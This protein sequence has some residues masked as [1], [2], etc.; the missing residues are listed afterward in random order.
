M[1]D[2]RTVG[3]LAASMLA[4]ALL[5][6]ACASGPRD[7]AGASSDPAPAGLVPVTVEVPKGMNAAPLNIAR[8]ALVPRGAAAKH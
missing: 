1:M 4:V 3:R 6:S 8:Q 5:A 2:Y 7:P